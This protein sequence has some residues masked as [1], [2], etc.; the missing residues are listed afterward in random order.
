MNQPEIE[1]RDARPRPPKR[2]WVQFSL[3]GL[4]LLTLL[5]ALGLGW[6]ASG[7]R[8]AWREERA[9][10]AIEE[11]AKV[12][13]NYSYEENLGELHDSAAPQPSDYPWWRGVLGN[14]YFDEP[15]K[16]CVP[17][18]VF[19]EENAHWVGDLL[20]LRE[21]RV[22]G[23]SRNMDPGGLAVVGQLAEL[24][25]IDCDRLDL[26]DADIATWG[27]LTKL[28]AVW[29]GSG[30][31]TATGMSGLTKNLVRLEEL[32]CS[33]SRFGVHAFGNLGQ[34]PSL[35]KLNLQNCR[36]TDQDFSSLA[37]SPLVELDLSGTNIADDGL[38]H[39]G[40]I[41]TLKRLKLNDTPITDAG[42]AHLESL[43]SLEEL[44]LSFTQLNGAG[45]SSIGKLQNLLA[46]DL[47]NT[48][49]QSLSGWESNSL[50]NLLELHL[51]E[52]K[53]LD[54]SLQVLASLGALEYLSLGRVRVEDTGYECL[55]RKQ[56]R[57]LDLQHASSP[58]IPMLLRMTTLEELHLP[59]GFSSESQQRI[60]AGLPACNVIIEPVPNWH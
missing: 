16:L 59:M 41:T 39:I 38:R 5:S 27:N 35:R 3:R 22:V 17:T 21:L 52:T 15:V 1:Q 58:C 31:F 33:G 42:L 51:R 28:R 14:A 30:E 48:N 55:Q 12:S 23:P 2:R 54:G 40:R 18:V 10:A 46:L 20:T 29:L 24:Q 6:I 7:L 56:L 44:D 34:L 8:S 57:H 36:F 47:S 49:F 4:L 45:L 50:S 11:I 32:H 37:A 26:T 53:I 19:T 25:T 43:Q 9:I 60:R 13:I